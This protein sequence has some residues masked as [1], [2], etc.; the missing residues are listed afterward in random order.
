LSWT[1]TTG[2]S[3]GFNE[4]GYGVAAS[5]SGELVAVG[6]GGNSILYSDGTIV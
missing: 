1:G 6:S 4:H 3:F 5:S 2:S